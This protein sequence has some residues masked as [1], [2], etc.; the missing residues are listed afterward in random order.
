ME[1]ILPEETKEIPVEEGKLY[2][3][4]IIGAGPAGMTAAVYAARKKL[5][6]LVISK[7]VG[8]Q[9]LLTSSIENYMGYQ[10]IG[11]ELA[12]SSFRMMTSAFR[13]RYSL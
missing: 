7:D 2:D 1:F 12:H 9:P 5:D 11:T 10:G 6:T 8:G 3:L 4:I 13:P